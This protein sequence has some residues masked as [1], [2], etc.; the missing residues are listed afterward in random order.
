MGIPL[1]FSLLRILNASSFNPSYPLAVVLIL[2]LILFFLTGTLLHHTGKK[3]VLDMIA[4]AQAWERAGIYR[5]AEQ[6]Y[7]KALR[8]YDSFLLSPVYLERTVGKKLAGSVSG[9][10]LASGSRNPLL[11]RCVPEYLK[12]DPA[13]EDVAVFWLKQAA[14]LSSTDPD[15][16]DQDILTLIAENHNGNIQVLPFLADIFLK[17]QRTDFTARKIFR[18]TLKYTR[19]KSN[20]K[21]RINELLSRME[22]DRVEPPSEVDIRIPE[23]ERVSA[24][25]K[26]KAALQAGFSSLADL[27]FSLLLGLGS[28]GKQI[29]LRT[30]S[31]A[32][33]GLAHIKSS[34]NLLRYARRVVLTAVLAVALA[35][36]V[37][38]ALHLFKT[39][40]PEKT[41]EKIEKQTVPKPF[42]LQVAAY[43][44]PRHARNYVNK[45]QNEGLDATYSKSEGGGKTWYLVR[46]SSFSDKKS[47]ASYGKE[48][49]EKGIIDDF[50]VDN[51]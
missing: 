15:A 24:A 47:A 23:P 44:E 36:A 41:A 50:F 43:L 29:C 7:L 4:R 25:P 22:E 27:L 21:S 28:T 42:T 39:K 37:N 14:S 10:L 5:K 51:R 49:K 6:Y 32:V 46:V 1:S 26:R 34:D 8:I 9:F 48:L 38:T 31:L 16:V 19:E 30:G 33:K 11:E 35:F 3:L 20:L 17:L 45:L 40:V 12:I 2:L 13:D 18:E